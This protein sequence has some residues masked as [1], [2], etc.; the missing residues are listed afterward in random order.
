MQ[1]L[2]ARARGKGLTRPRRW[3]SRNWVGYDLAALSGVLHLMSKN[4]FGITAMAYTRRGE[5]VSLWGGATYVG[6]VVMKKRKPRMAGDEVPP[7]LAAMESSIFARLHSLVAHCCATRYDDGSARTV[8]WWTVKTMGSAWIVEVKDPDTCSR[9][10]VVQ[11][12]LDDALVL[13]ALLLDSEDAPWEP[14][15]WMKSQAAK[16][17]K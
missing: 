3:S 5:T 14:D 15:P 17:K 4:W 13:A 6:D 8:G 2:V 9:L 16:K 11:Q 1:K 7:H 12:T 10:T